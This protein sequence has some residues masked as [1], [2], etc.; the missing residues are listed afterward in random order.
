MKD[1]NYKIEEKFLFL[2]DQASTR[3]H[4][5]QDDYFGTTAIILSLLAQD[6]FIE[7]KKELRKYLKKISKELLYLQK[8][9][10][11]KKRP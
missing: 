6:E 5:K 8:N 1:K 11:I 2:R 9:Y 3:K 10:Q 7:D 4:I